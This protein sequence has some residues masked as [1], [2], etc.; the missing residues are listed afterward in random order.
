LLSAFA[1]ALPSARWLVAPWNAHGQWQEMASESKLSG[2]QVQDGTAGLS[3]QESRDQQE[4][5][6]VLA[7]L[8]L[9]YVSFARSILF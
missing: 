2:L 5:K 9:L 1:P 6:D 8:P 4:H 7:Y 3:A